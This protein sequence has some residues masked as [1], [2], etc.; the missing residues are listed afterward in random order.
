[1]GHCSH[2]PP[3]CSPSCK[4]QT[5]SWQSWQAVEIYKTVWFQNTLQVTAPNSSSHQR[6]KNKKYFVVWPQLISE[7]FAD[8]TKRK[9][10]E[11]MWPNLISWNGKASMKRNAVLE[12]TLWF[13]PQCFSWHNW[14]TRW[15]K[16]CN[17][18]L[19]TEESGRA[20]NGTFRLIWIDKGNILNTNKTQIKWTQMW[21]AVFAESET[22]GAECMLYLWVWGAGSLL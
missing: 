18:R 6:L 15:N 20:C 17:I 7:S 22:F 8:A 13:S 1:M 16:P 3:M 5:S 10:L 4:R 12:K 9:F 11:N 21:K 19:F 14:L 2:G